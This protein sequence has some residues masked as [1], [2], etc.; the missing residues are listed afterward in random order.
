MVQRDYEVCPVFTRWQ[1]VC[2]VCGKTFYID[3]EPEATK[4]H[5]NIILD[6]MTCDEHPIE[7]QTL[8]LA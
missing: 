2:P 5:I 3:D 8:Q 1:V 7:Q 6:D 4:E